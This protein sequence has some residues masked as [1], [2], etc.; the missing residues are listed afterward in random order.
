MP[1][2]SNDIIIACHFEFIVSKN[3]LKIYVDCMLDFLEH[4][5]NQIT[6]IE[7]LIEALQNHRLQVIICNITIDSAKKTALFQEILCEFDQ[8]FIKFITYII[9]TRK[10]KL[11][12]DI[13]RQYIVAAHARNN[14][15]HINITI[16]KKIDDTERQA[17][18]AK[19]EQLWQEKLFI[20]YAI[21]KN[22]L[23]GMII[24]RNGKI[25][26]LSYRKKIQIINDVVSYNIEEIGT[27]NSLNKKYLAI[28]H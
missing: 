20:T 7:H 1:F 8:K 3:N 21:D 10:E 13:L 9:N 28:S 25:L 6:K 12:T 17:I 23:Q 22:L 5:E 19:C 2:T 24:Q 15:S 16:A 26:D 4:N 11:L 18:Q 27:F 14:V